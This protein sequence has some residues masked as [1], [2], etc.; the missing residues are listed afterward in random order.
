M[1]IGDCSACLVSLEA[2]REFGKPYTEEFSGYGALRVHSCGMSDHLLES[3]T[4]VRG[5]GSLDVGS[6]TS[7]AKIRSFLGKDFLI[8]V[9]PPLEVVLESADEKS[10]RNWVRKTLEENAGGPLEMK[11]HLET[12]YSLSNLLA[13]KEELQK[14]H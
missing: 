4:S 7:V 5:L 8:E 6:N 14:Q 13:I 2:Y 9:A 12:G 10:C 11:C 1:H 3:M